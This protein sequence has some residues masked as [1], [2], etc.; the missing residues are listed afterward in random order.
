M[1]L[2]QT[3][4]GRYPG[5]QLRVL[6]PFELN[7]FAITSRTNEDTEEFFPVDRRCVTTSALIAS[8][9][10]DGIRVEIVLK[11]WLLVIAIILSPDLT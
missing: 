7:W 3:T 11:L 8:K 2:T 4:A 1:A 6:L 9:S 5:E 10:A